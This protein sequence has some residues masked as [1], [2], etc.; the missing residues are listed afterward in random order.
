[1]KINA[2]VAHRADNDSTYRKEWA[3]Q[4]LPGATQKISRQ[5]KKREKERSE[6]LKDFMR[7]FEAH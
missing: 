2:V 5:T 1:M 6:G 7:T 4:A 3:A